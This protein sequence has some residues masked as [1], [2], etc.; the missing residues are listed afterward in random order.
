MAHPTVDT[1]D[2]LLLLLLFPSF[3]RQKLKPVQLRKGPAEV[4]HWSSKEVRVKAIQNSS[5]A[6]NQRA[7]VLAGGF[8]R[9]SRR[10][11]LFNVSLVLYLHHIRRPRC[12]RPPKKR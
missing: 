9:S 2:I 11:Y 1:T 6:R 4:C 8:S 3:L 12:S 7:S 5:V 10:E